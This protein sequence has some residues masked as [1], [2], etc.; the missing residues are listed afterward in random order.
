MQLET[1]NHVFRINIIR[2]IFLSWTV[3]TQFIKSSMQNP[4]LPIFLAITLKRPII[5]L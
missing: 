1:V 4:V 5:L 3:S 2:S